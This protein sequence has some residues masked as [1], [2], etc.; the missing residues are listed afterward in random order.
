MTVDKCAKCDTHAK[1]INGKCKCREGWVGNG[2][3]CIKGTFVHYLKNLG[4]ELFH[5]PVFLIS[6]I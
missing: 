5:K 3:E 4:R 6:Q 2:Y 1:C